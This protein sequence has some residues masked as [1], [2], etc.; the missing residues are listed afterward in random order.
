[1]VYEE[2]SARMRTHTMCVCVCVCVHAF[3]MCSVQNHVSIFWRKFVFVNSLSLY[4]A[5]QLVQRKM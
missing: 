5:E 4:A 2:W 1:M 3:V